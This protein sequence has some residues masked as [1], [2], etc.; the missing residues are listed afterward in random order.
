MSQQAACPQPIVVHSKLSRRGTAE[1]DALNHARTGT[2][3][4][5]ANGRRADATTLVNEHRAQ[6]GEDARARRAE[7]V[8][9]SHGAAKHVAL[10]GREAKNVHVGKGNAGKGL[11]ALN[12]IDLVQ[13]QT[14]ALEGL[15]QCLGRSRRKLLGGYMSRPSSQN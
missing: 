6:C 15:R 1:D 7:R 11:V 14:C 5:V 8:A 3:T 2:A 10:V 4:A 13:R 9:E 12:K